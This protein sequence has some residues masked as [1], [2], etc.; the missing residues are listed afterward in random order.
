MPI[1]I[2]TTLHAHD[3]SSDAPASLVD[4]AAAVGRWAGCT[5]PEAIIESGS[6]SGVGRR[7]AVVRTEK[8]DLG[9][10]EGWAWT[11]RISHPDADDPNV[12][13]VVVVEA[14][15]DESQ[16]ATEVAI[17]LLR[18]SLDRRVRLH[19][20]NP[21]APNLIGE[22]IDAGGIE[23]V[24][25]DI[26]IWSEPRTLRRDHLDSLLDVLASDERR[27]PVIGVSEDAA[28]GWLAVNLPRLAHSVAGM[29]HVWF[30]PN[31][32][33]WPLS[34]HL[35]PRLDV[36]NAAV[37]IWWPGFDSEADPY[38]HHL[39]LR[40]RRNV[41]ADVVRLVQTAAR[42]RFMPP[43]GIAAFRDQLRQ[44]DDAAFTAEL[45][46]LTTTDSVAPTDSQAMLRMQDQVAALME[47]RDVWRGL[48]QEEERQRWSLEFT[49]ETQANQLARLRSA[50]GG[51]ETVDLD[52]L[53]PAEAFLADVRRAYAEVVC[54][55]AADR[56]DWPLLHLRLHPEFL[57]SFEELQ[58][59][60]HEKIVE[61]CAQVACDRARTIT[62]RHVHPLREGD[63]GDAP[64]RIRGSDGAAA[65]RCALQKGSPGSRQLHWWRVSAPGSEPDV[66]EFAQV[67]HHDNFVIPI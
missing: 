40:D 65:W 49:L 23:C 30:V 46:R 33:T 42:D 48:A 25:G 36:F 11:F 53:D 62:A 37:R 57:R 5:S 21:A 51:G 15:E 6:W 9:A 64:A 59:V 18:E 38:E 43:R 16:P 35:P 67:G 55:T 52:E 58:G 50:L 34:E 54:A 24:D 20:T 2:A 28:R 3:F 22:L 39:F 32:V 45:A 14:V 12:E 44:R 31:D 8:L 56:K 63:A 41:E 10:G 27:L 1:E 47:D 26:P 66:I 17:S 60:D 7:N 19:S 29:A 61:V 4:I 13:W